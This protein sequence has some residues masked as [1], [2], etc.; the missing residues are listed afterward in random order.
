MSTGSQDTNPAR[1]L[2]LPPNYLNQI[3]HIRNHSATVFRKASG[4]N[5]RIRIVQI[6]KIVRKK[7]QFFRNF[8]RW[9]DFYFFTLMFFETSQ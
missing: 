1:L 7:S 3:D 4:H 2:S 8:K 5:P 6:L 9:D